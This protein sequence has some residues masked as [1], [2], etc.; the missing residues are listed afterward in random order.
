MKK[1][2]LLIPVFTLLMAF[3][4]G[5]TVWG[6]NTQNAAHNAEHPHSPCYDP[7]VPGPSAVRADPYVNQGYIRVYWSAPNEA[8]IDATGC[9]AGPPD[10]NG[11]YIS[12]WESRNGEVTGYSLSRNIWSP[13]GTGGWTRIGRGW[14]ILVGET[15][16][17]E[18]RDYDIVPG[19]KYRYKVH[20]LAT[21]ESSSGAYSWTDLS[22][23]EYTPAYHHGTPRA[24]P[25]RSSG[26]SGIG[27]S[28]GCAGHRRGRLYFHGTPI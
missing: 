26:G 1:T 17:F 4:I 24:R 11:N 21:I 28:R 6:H 12:Y 14:D 18:Y 7:D 27:D 13:D 25:G 16:A 22:D 19:W 10:E 5:T 23:E 15:T 20:T 9:S 8:L 2:N 3:C